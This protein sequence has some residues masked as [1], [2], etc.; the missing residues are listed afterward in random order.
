MHRLKNYDELI[1]KLPKEAKCVVSHAAA[2]PTKFLNHLSKNY[3]KVKN[4]EIIHMV[5]MGETAYCDLNLPIDFTI[6]HNSLFVG[7]STRR[8]V[9][10]NLA[11]YTPVHFSQIPRYIRLIK[12]EIAV[13]QISRTINGRASLG[14]SVDYGIQ[15]FYSAKIK[16][17][18]QNKF[19]PYT[20]GDGELNIEDFDYIISDN[21]PLHELITSEEFDPISD[22]ISNHIINLIKDNATLQLGIGNIPNYVLKKLIKLKNLGLHSEMISDGIIDLVENGVIN[23]TKKM[24]NP[25]KSTV[26]FA[27]GTKKLYDYLDLNENFIFKSVEYINNFKNITKNENVVSINS[28]IEV[29]LEGQVNSE[30]LNGLQ[31]SGVGGQVDFVR[32]AQHSKNGISIIALPSTDSSKSH[33]RIVKKIDTI[34]TI[35][36]SRNDVHYVCTEYGLV[37]LF[38]ESLSNRKT[39]LKSISHPNFHAKLI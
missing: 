7:K 37:N 28:A 1:S 15:A 32:A 14:V 4:Y 22:K 18:I 9:A 39:L 8:A 25:K 20:F 21:T 26:S 12:P 5:P 19:M 10:E 34:N 2:M 36:T 23:N 31:F 24:L 17:G 13:L 33:S 29:D 30:K 38:G 11:D 3:K 35:T 6:K 27:L 16:V